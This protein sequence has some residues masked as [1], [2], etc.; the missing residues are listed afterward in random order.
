M[1]E[2]GSEILR[3]LIRIVVRHLGILE[4]N[5]ATCCGVS[6]AQS[7]AIVTGKLMKIGRAHV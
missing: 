4:K 7:Q 3:E 1:S 5:D 2:K 6:L